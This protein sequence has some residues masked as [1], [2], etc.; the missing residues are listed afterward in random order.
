MSEGLGRF[1]VR[2]F[3]PF[4][5][6]EFLPAIAPMGT[7]GFLT[8][9][10]VCGR[11]LGEYDAGMKVSYSPDVDAAYIYLV[12][13]RPGEA[14]HTRTCEGASGGTINLDFDAF[15]RLLGIELLGARQLLPPDVIEQAEIR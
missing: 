15:G 8:K 9:P 12:E 14:R 6:K 5:T 13:I 3:F 10:G 4:K 7:N 1:G 11:V 2:G